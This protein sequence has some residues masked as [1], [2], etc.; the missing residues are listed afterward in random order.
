MLL[1]A[2]IAPQLHTNQMAEERETP[3]LLPHDCIAPSGKRQLKPAPSTRTT[4]AEGDE[5]EGT[6][7]LLPSTAAP[8]RATIAP[9][10]E[11]VHASTAAYRKCACT[12]TAA[13]LTLLPQRQRR[14]VE[15]Y[16]SCQPAGLAGSPADSSCAYPRTASQRARLLQ[17]NPPLAHSTHL[18]STHVCRRKCREVVSKGLSEC[19]EN[20]PE[21]ERWS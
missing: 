15:R 10:T 5:S 6:R 4:R 19:P 8:H 21:R 12:S 3:P 2:R 17:T 9:C 16:C 14:T 11:P 1:P 20:L 7:P 13:P 18:S